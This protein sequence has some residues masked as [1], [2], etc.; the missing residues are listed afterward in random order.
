[1][2]EAGSRPDMAVAAAFAGKVG[3]QRAAVMFACLVFAVLAIGSA[4][5]RET[6]F[7]P[8]TSPTVPSVLA[9]QATIEQSQRELVAGNLAQA[10]RLADQAVRLAPVEPASTALLGAT[11]LALGDSAG[12]DRAFRIAGQ[13]GW[14]MP[15]TQIYWMNQALASGDQRVAALRLDALLRQD[16][17]LVGDRSLMAPLEATPAGRGALVDRL[18]G[19][20]GWLTDYANSVYQL[21]ADVSLLRAEVFTELA[22]RGQ[23]LGCIGAGPL[24]R[25]L[26]E[27][28]LPQQAYTLWLA[29]C[30]DHGPGLI[31]DP[32]FAHLDVHQSNS[33][34][35]WSIVGDSDVSVN[36]EPDAQGG[37]SH[38][39]L[40]SSASFARKVLVQLVMAPPGTYRV[41]WRART[42]D[43]H[44]TNRV[45]ATLSCAADGHD[46]LPATLDPA[47][48]R[49]VASVRVD[50]QC[51]GSWLGFALQP[52]PDSVT[53]DWVALDKIG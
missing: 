5:D 14:R 47:S 50:G 32:A 53:L 42:P 34:F 25:N 15:L 43:G 4:L 35:E 40:A 52:G 8:A 6:Y 26:V 27:Q 22:R 45:I 36:L 2:A 30:P 46:W 10:G 28:G 16:P 3:Q 29:H 18:Q 24:T 12:A 44:P 9:V 21:P 33:Q 49:S 23:I 39:V 48:G 11:R 13:F 38:L 20:P 31:A 7:R 51:P 19:R 17:T 1:M 37:A 41:S